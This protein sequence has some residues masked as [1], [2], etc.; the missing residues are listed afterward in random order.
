MRRKINPV[1]CK[2]LGPFVEKG[3]EST[4][5]TAVSLLMKQTI[6]IY[7]T[8]HNVYFAVKRYSDAPRGG[9]GPDTKDRS[10]VRMYSCGPFRPFRNVFYSPNAASMPSVSSP[11]KSGA[12]AGRRAH[13]QPP[14]LDRVVVDDERKEKRAAGSEGAAIVGH[15]RYK[16]RNDS[17]GSRDGPQ[18]Y[19]RTLLGVIFF[20]SLHE[21]LV[22]A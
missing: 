3:T 7:A 1:D 5:L 8:S 11:S 6:G 2:I 4:F 12:G 17:A 15:V 13:P 18:E 14:M 16:Y 9:V 10:R 22:C 20:V 21:R 19:L